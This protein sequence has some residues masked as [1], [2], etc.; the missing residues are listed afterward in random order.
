LTPVGSEPTLN[1]QVQGMYHD[2]SSRAAGWRHR[3][4]VGRKISA[5]R[6]ARKRQWKILR[7]KSKSSGG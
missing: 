5:F 7:R 1:R 6:S 2:R 3:S 4:N